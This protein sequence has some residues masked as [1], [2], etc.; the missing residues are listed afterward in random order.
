MHERKAVMAELSDGFVAIPGG[1][2]TLEELFEIWTWAQLGLHAKPCGVLDAGNYFR[3]LLSFLDHLV[4]E[5]FLR[6]EHRAMLLTAPTGPELLD[7]LAGYRPPT[8]EKWI[9]RRSR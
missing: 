3:D 8:V 4:H 7:L 1:I 5:G 9:D 6:A 2:G